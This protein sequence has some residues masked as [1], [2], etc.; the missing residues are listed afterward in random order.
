[1]T[2][3]IK[4]PVNLREFMSM[5][6]AFRSKRHKKDVSMFFHDPFFSLAVTHL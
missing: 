6:E 2:D 5:R 3:V 1:M 4:C